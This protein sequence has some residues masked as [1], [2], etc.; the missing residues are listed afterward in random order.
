M[1]Q[2]PVGAVPNLVDDVGLKVHVER[3]RHVLARGRLR[4]EGAEAIVV[5]RRGAL[6]KAAVGLEDIS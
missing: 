1:E 4:E 5:G 6:Q 3:P 2:T